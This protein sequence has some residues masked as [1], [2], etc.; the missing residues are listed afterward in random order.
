MDKDFSTE[1]RFAVFF[2]GDNISSEYL[3]AIMTEIAKKGDV[4]IKRV[5]GD[6]TTPNMKSWKEK[7][8][9]SP[10]RVFQQFRN[11][12]N[13]TDNTIIMDSIELAIKNKNINAFCIVSTDFGYYS[14]ALRLRENGKHVLG[15]GRE[16]S[17]SIWQ[18]SCN[19]FVTIE[20]IFKGKEL[21]K[22]KNESIKSIEDGL[23]VIEY[24]LFNSR[25]NTD[26]W[27]SFSDFGFTIRTKYPNFDP[28]SYM[29][30]NLLQ[31]I[32]KFPDDLEIK[33]D[34]CFPPNYWLRDKEKYNKE[35]K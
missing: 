14:L 10:I 13:A 11:G 33:S 5:Y 28:R 35:D 19:E 18:N 31:L 2:D 22:Q 26:G 6:F 29:C 15:I 32:R 34:D 7:V 30:N 9:D 17:K 27:I 4:I 23:D 8:F 21:E 12:P 16:N 24:G 25:I 20:N 3:D 1:K